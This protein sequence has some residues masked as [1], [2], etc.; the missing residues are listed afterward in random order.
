MEYVEGTLLDKLDS[1]DPHARK[2]KSIVEAYIATIMMES[3]R[4]PTTLNSQH[5][6]V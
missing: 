3:I 2:S 1:N 5:P 4:R 6:L